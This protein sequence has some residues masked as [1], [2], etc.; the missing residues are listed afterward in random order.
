MYWCMSCL[1]R[2]Y[3]LAT[4]T[5]HGI[6]GTFRHTLLF[7]PPWDG[8]SGAYFASIL[9]FCVPCAKQEP[10]NQTVYMS[11]TN[12]PFWRNAEEWCLHHQYEQSS[13]LI[14]RRLSL[15]HNMYP[16]KSC[17]CGA[18]GG[19]WGSGGGGYQLSV[20]LGQVK[21]PSRMQSKSCL[22]RVLSI[23]TVL[24]WLSMG[25]A[26]TILWHR[27]AAVSSQILTLHTSIH[28]AS[29][30]EPEGSY[31][32]WET[33]LWQRLCLWQPLLCQLAAYCF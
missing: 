16:A 31:S 1:W 32:R 5:V 7:M 23:P 20:Q 8:H 3:S 9:Q 15:I 27:Q 18:G 28:Q 14:N 12:D 24:P 26:W 33:S 19:G 17:K 10:C 29:G 22:S 25:Y 30:D 11:A 2:R 21:T 6:Q 4:I 13:Q